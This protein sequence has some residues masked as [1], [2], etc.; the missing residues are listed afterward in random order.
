M[1]GGGHLPVQVGEG[2]HARGKGGYL[3]VVE[4][5]PVGENEEDVSSIKSLHLQLQ[6]G[7]PRQPR[8]YRSDLVEAEHQPIGVK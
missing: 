4:I 6:L 1:K 5:Q 3:V 7:H 2:S 8:G